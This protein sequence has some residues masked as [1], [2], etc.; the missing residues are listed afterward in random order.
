VDK[1]RRQ[2][3]CITFSS[4]IAE[5]RVPAHKELAI[6]GKKRS[7]GETIYLIRK[8]CS[9]RKMRVSLT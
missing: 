1:Q 2:R 8:E 7:L 6:K 4:S 3:D 5:E 9:V